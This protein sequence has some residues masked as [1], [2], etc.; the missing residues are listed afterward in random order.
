LIVP[1]GGQIAFALFSEAIA[2]VSLQGGASK[3]DGKD[4]LAEG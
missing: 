1:G 2:A 3:K 4:I